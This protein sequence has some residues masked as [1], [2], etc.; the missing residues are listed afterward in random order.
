MLEAAHA[1]P[2]WV[3][4]AYLIAGVCFILAL[5][6][7]SGPESSRRGN[8]TG[9][10]GMAIAVVT[11]LVTHA[12]VGRAGDWLVTGEAISSAISIRCLCRNPRRDHHRRNH[13]PRYRPQD[14]DDGDAAAGRRLP[15]PRRHGRGAGRRRGLPQPGSVRDCGADHADRQPVIHQHLPAKPDRN[16]S[17]RRDRRDHLLGLG[18]RLPQAQR[19]HVGQA[20]PAAA[21]PCHQSRHARRDPRTDR[22]LHPG[23]GAVGVLHRR[24]PELRDRLPADHPH[25]RR[26]HA[27]RDLDAQ[28]LFR[29]GR[30]RDGLHAAQQRDDHHRR[31]GRKLGRD[32]A[33]TS[34]AGR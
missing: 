25:R 20:D 29:V 4:L 10:L 33:A 34:C 19:Q 3:L 9:M 2:A 23:P 22:L 30:R 31:A 16:G 27:G 17:R 18:D 11:T 28:Q 24:G 6:G 7:L 5:R 12:P 15:Q 14:P 8:R 1:Q 32:P 21:A 13:R 26:R